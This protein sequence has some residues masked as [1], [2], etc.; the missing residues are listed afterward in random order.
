MISWTK[1]EINFLTNNYKSLSNDEISKVL[2]KTK[3][4]IDSKA[5]RLGIKKDTNYISNIN[6]NRVSNNRWIENSWKKEEIDYLVSNLQNLSNIELSSKLKKSV[7]SIVSMCYRLKIS[8]DSKYNKEYIEKECLKYIT[9]SELRIS[10]PNLYHWLY[11]NGKL[12]DVTKHMMNISY[13]TPQLILANI[14]SI[15]KIN[16]KYNDREAIKPYEI[17]IY[18]P[19]NKFGI[20][21]DGIYYHDSSKNFK[22]SICNKLD[23]KLLIIDELNLTKRNFDYYVENIKIQIIKNLNFINN[24]LNTNIN[25]DEIKNYTPNKSEIFKNLFDIDK[26]KQICLKYDN[27]TTFINEQKNI[28]NKIYYLGLLK[29]FTSHM[30]V[31]KISEGYKLNYIIEKDNYYKIGDVVLIEYWYNDMIC[32]VKITEQIGRKYKVSHNI[33]QSKIFNAPDEIIKSSDIIDKAR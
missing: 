8:R 21:Y 15:F 11:K 13:S 7:A 16:F 33:P 2:K 3:K 20:E 23:I 6:R 10:D 27:Y 18:Y 1:E 17:D 4:S 5:I 28:Y 24:S 31:D 19:I 32:T 29:D 14:M 9:K 25:P 12:K 26:I 30:V 22:T